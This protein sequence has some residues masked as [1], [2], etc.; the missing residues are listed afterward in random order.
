MLFASSVRK[1]LFCRSVG[2]RDYNTQ[3]CDC[4]TAPIRMFGVEFPVQVRS[5]D[6][7]RR[8]IPYDRPF[9]CYVQPPHVRL[10]RMFISLV[11]PRSHRHIE[12]AGQR[13]RIFRRKSAVE[14]IRVPHSMRAQSGQ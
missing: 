8:T 6:Q 9:R 12:Y 14:E 2:S 1:V 11:I 5:Q 13:V 10:E 7:V 3:P 4:Y